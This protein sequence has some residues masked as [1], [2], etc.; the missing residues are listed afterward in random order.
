MES[1]VSM[2]LAIVWP[3]VVVPC[4]LNHDTSV[5]ETF[6]GYHYEFNRWIVTVNQHSIDRCV[7]VCHMGSRDGFKSVF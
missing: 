5:N 4:L 1:T 6:Q 3:F 2:L 7:L